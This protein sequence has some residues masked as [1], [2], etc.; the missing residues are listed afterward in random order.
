MAHTFR[1]PMTAMMRE[2]AAA[3]R[4]ARATGAPIDEV[5]AMRAERLARPARRTVLAGIAATTATAIAPSR[6]L[7]I[8]KPRVAIIGGGLAG[9]NCAYLLWKRAGVAA[10]VFE[11][12]NSLGGRVQ[13]LRNYFINNQIAE[14]H[15]EFISVR[16][17]ATLDL[18]R[19]FGLT[20]WNTDATPPGKKN[21]Y[22]FDGKLYSQADLNADW[23]SFGWKLFH[24]AVRLVP[25]AN[26]RNYSKTAYEWDHMSVSEWVEQ[27]VPGGG[28]SWFGKLCLS[29]VLDE[30]GGPPDEQSALN[31]VYNLGYDG[32]SGDGYQPKRYPQL[33]GSNEKWQIRDGNDQ[34]VTGLA[35]RL[36]EGG[37]RLEHRLVGLR[38]NNDR[39]YTCTFARDQ[40]TVEHV[41]DHVVIAIPFTTLR[42]VDLDRVQFSALKRLAI[43]TLPLGNNA[44]IQIQVAGSPWR[45]DG[46]NGDLLSLEG[47]QSGWDGSFFQQAK[48]PGATEIYLALPGG[49]EGKG[50]AA[51]YGL[52]FGRYQ[53]P[54]PS[55]LVADSL[56]DL[57]QTFPGITDA[58]A[59]GPRLAWVND[60]NIDP[61]LL[62]AWSQYNV[63]QYTGFSG[64]EKLQEGNVHFAGEHTSLEFQGFMEGAL[65]SGGRAA[66]EILGS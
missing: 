64:V 36:P 8:G 26:Y 61:H 37:V 28:A 34:L 39:T 44:K 23:R 40:G 55:E 48:R 63:G 21:A 35:A 32:S 65:R 45:R 53:G 19:E 49:R 25:N 57:E 13:T 33:F 59:R 58:W 43:K 2:A 54:A 60:G 6:S 16:H 29:V 24:H 11:W 22:R 5:G 51:K 9:L 10:T 47:A 62:G 17:K 27:Y 1:S 14:Q 18:A 38:E 4:E 20:L 30:Y 3:C 66:R 46:Y 52:K 42:E 56:S 41:A 15:G 12:K 31:L 7:A 50:L